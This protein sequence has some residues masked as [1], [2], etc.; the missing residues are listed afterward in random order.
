MEKSKQQIKES[1]YA[2]KRMIDMEKIFI[3]FRFP[4][5]NFG[6]DIFGQASGMTL[7]CHPR[8]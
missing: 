2:H 8:D 7:S 1:Q 3:F 4:I 6:N 5:E